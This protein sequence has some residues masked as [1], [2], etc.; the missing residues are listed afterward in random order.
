MT[1]QLI[2]PEIDYDRIDSVRGM[3]ITIVTTAR[4]DDEGRAFLRHSASP[5]RRGDWMS[6]VAK[7]ALHPEAATDPEVQGA[8]VYPV[9]TMR[10]PKAVFPQVSYVELASNHGP[11]RAVPA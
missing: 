9:P 2:F 11:R 4:N 6:D 10:T 1:E 5:F 8:G 7:K 3:D